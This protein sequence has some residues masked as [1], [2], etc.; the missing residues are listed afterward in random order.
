MTGERGQAL[1]LAVIAL[2]VAAATIVGLRAA[3]ERILA[4]VR[5]RRAGEA[6]IEAAGAAIADAQLDFIE[7]LRDELGGRTTQ[8]TRSELDAFAANPLVAERA[9]AA[10]DALSAANGGPLV[11][12]IEIRSGGR[13]LEL[14]LT[15]GAHH[16]RAAIEASCCRH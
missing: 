10:A 6:A 11:G 2:A 8:A 7:S 15:V 12:E 4:D 3:Q 14:A 16:Q 9:R 13:T 1:A 5:E